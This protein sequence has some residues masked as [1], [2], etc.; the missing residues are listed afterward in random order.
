MVYRA[1]PRP[2]L[3]VAAAAALREGSAQGVLLYSRR[4]ADAF[5]LALRAEGLAPLA[6]GVTCYCLSTAVA[7]PLAAVTAGPIRIAAQPDQ[8]SL[9]ALLEPRQPARDDSGSRV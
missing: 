3:T 1:E 4:S 6:E 2:R 9:F 8:I 5:A 7:E